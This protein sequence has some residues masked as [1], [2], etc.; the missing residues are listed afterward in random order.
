MKNFSHFYN[1]TLYSIK[2]ERNST[3][4]EVANKL[5]KQQQKKQLESLYIEHKHSLC[6]WLKR[7]YSKNMA[8]A[9]EVV[10]KAFTKMLEM[11]GFEHV[12]NPKAFLYTVA[13]NFALLD[14]RAHTTSQKFIDQELHVFSRNVEEMTPERIYSSQAQFKCLIEGM[15][16]LS[17][18]Q[19]QIL[20]L[21]R[22]EGKTYEQIQQETGFSQADI[23]RQIKTSLSIIR[24]ELASQ[25]KNKG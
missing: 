3:E 2:T 24:E 22:I 11:D 10:H 19:R 15:A 25:P 4:T 23:S 5:K 1:S 21:S 14:V 7:R 12:H 13:V 18:K 17:H 20:R 16:L 8:D 9:E 6:E